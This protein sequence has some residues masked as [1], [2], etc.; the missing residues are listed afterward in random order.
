MTKA[1]ILGAMLPAV[2]CGQ[3]DPSALLQQARAKI[4]E[5]VEKLPKYTC[6]QTVHR[7]RFE[8]FY[9]RK[10]SGCGHVEEAGAANRGPMVLLAWRDQFKLDVTI[11][12]GTEIFSWAGAQ[13]F[14]SADV[15]EI[16]GGGLTGTGDFGPFLM[17]V[18]GGK[19][20]VYQYV[21]SEPEQRRAYAVYRYHVPVPAS[22]YQI[23]VGARPEG[24]ATL[25]YEGQ[26]WIDPQSA[27]LSRMT[28]AVPKPP[29]ESET[30]RI[31]TTIDYQR[32]PIDGAPLLLPQSTVLKLWEPDGARYENRIAYAGCRAFRSES[33][34][35]PEVEAT[36]GDSTAAATVSGGG[37]AAPKTRVAVPAGLTLQIALRSKIDA[38]TS[39]AGDAIEGQ[40]VEAIHTRDGNLVAP[41][42]AIVQGRIVRFVEHSAPSHYWAVGLRFHSLGGVPVT[43]EAVPRSR[44]E[45]ILNGAPERRQGIGAFLFQG[46]RLALDER[47]VS[48]WKTAPARSM[49]N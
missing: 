33:V 8:V 39:F 24:L 3:V 40:L 30:C 23:K 2:L 26:F 34:F 7:S 1:A 37:S 45:Q 6:V 29:K 36:T 27:E 48:E 10:A 17:D 35:R 15:Q 5:S 13:V 49:R 11:S 46:D 28:I 25:A 43:L 4:V 22:H 41:Q 31:E 42:G 18:F 32:V 12:Q 9:G 38:E 44:E 21:G 47:F 20:S 14:Q 16:V 19:G